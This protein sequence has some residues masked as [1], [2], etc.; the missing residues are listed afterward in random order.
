MMIRISDYVI[1]KGF[2]AT[3]HFA[4]KGNN[5]KNRLY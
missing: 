2:K 4:V 5:V 1:S 3:H